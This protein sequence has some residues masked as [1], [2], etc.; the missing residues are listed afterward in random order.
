MGGSATD[1]LAGLGGNDLLIG[2]AGDDT[3][4]GGTGADVYVYHGGDGADK[5]R[6][7][8]GVADLTSADLLVIDN[9]NLNPVNVTISRV[10]I[11]GSSWEGSLMIDM[12]NGDSI[13]IAHQFDGSGNY[14]IEGVSFGGDN[15]LTLA[16]HT[17]GS[18][19]DDLVVGTSD[20]NYVQ[21]FE[22]DD[23]LVAGGGDDFVRGHAGD[24]TIFGGAGDD[25]LRGGDGADAYVFHTGDGA[26]MINDFDGVSDTSSVDTIIFADVTDIGDLSFS[27]VAVGGSSWL[28]SLLIE[29][30]SDSVQILHHFAGSGDYEVEQIM[31]ADGSTYLINDLLTA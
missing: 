31:L 1:Y 22:G 18:S 23:I 26:D 3:L 12:G 19:L 8:D 16:S 14:S 24:D 4:I 28:G 9:E 2:G 17:T 21:G 13:T 7:F 15:I 20:V 29:Y 6:D 11:G 10:A 27:Q 25:M 5:I 30:G